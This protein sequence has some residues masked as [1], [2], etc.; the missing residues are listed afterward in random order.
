M[1]CLGQYHRLYGQ[2]K[3]IVYWKVILKFAQEKV[4]LGLDVRGLENKRSAYFHKQWSEPDT[5]AVP[6]WGPG[7]T[8]WKLLANN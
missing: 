6:I 8:Y 5:E 3:Q 2:K 1:E 4:D 7:K